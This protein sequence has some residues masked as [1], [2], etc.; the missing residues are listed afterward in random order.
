MTTAGSAGRESGAAWDVKGLFDR[1]TAHRWDMA[2]TT[3]NERIARLERLRS[4]VRAHTADI[5]EAA[6][7][8]FGKAPAEME[9]TEV[10][11]TLE[12]L[13]HAI[14]M[15]PRWMRP[16]KVTTPLT[17][18]GA[19]SEIRYEPKG[20]VLVLSPWNYPFALAMNPLVAAIA[21]GNCV[22]LR[23][24]DKTR[25]SAQ[26]LRTVVSEALPE[27]EAVV[28]TGG[29]ELADALLELPFDHIF[30]T[31]SPSVG[32]KVMASAAR[33]LTPV[34]LE[35]GGKSPAVVDET[36]NLRTSAERIVWGKFV[37][38]GQT[39]IAPD[40][41]LVHESVAEGLVAAIRTAIEGAYGKEESDRLASVD[42][43]GVVDETSMK[44]LASV[45]DAA[46]GAGAKL[47]IGGSVDLEKRR[48][49]PTVLTEVTLESPIMRDEIFGPIL[50]VLTFRSVDEA[51]AV[52]R[53]R[54]KPLALYVFAEAP[55][56][57]ERVLRA[58]SAG[59]TS[60]NN[61]LMH[62]VNPNLPFGGVGESGMG[63]YHGRHG[64]EALSHARAVLRQRMPSATGFLYP[65]YEGRK[66]MIA[67][68][69]RIV[70]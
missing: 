26:A 63:S 49:S 21:A 58:T 24:S 64:F 5:C 29:R 18:A 40:Y 45:L 60:V 41:V 43:C 67:L 6:R 22:M 14:R 54:P 1:Q 17:L 36:A 66:R 10:L 31:G 2:R 32:R 34:T 25:H 48:I 39:C 37:N 19:T 27:E 11:P 20:V 7:A 12:E 30:F 53:S 55:D 52:I 59:G 13:N 44:R 38:A 69:R 28:L 62:Y 16:R 70:G 35:L 4:A 61:V 3:A 50:P 47:A 65:P 42:L 33:N 23:P 57:I 8:D 46:L 15:L 68:F 51:T 56:R 9:I